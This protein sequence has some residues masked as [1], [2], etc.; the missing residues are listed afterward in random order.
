MILFVCK[1]HDLK[2]FT[3][4]ESPDVISISGTWLC[5]E[6]PDQFLDLNGYIIFTNGEVMEMT[7]M[8]VFLFP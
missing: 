6:Y 5:S 4:T 1:V 8:D 3:A 7:R 2:V